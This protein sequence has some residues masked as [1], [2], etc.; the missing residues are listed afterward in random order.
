MTGQFGC[1]REKELPIS[2]LIE[3]ASGQDMEF[4]GPVESALGSHR[5]CIPGPHEV[6]RD[7]PCLKGLLNIFAL[8]QELLVSKQYPKI[9]L[10]FTNQESKIRDLPCISEVLE[11]QPKVLLSNATLDGHQEPTIAMYHVEDVNTF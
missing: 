5:L 1:R 7:I 11:V 3:K 9:G 10:P 2:G 4:G 6:D 8:D